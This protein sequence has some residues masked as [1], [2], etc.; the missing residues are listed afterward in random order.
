M[1]VDVR[2]GKLSLDEALDAVKRPGAGGLA[3]FVG[4][5]RDESEGRAVMRLEY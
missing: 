4:V 2:E 1:K 5:V 3:T